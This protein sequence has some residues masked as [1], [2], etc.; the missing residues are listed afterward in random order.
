MR[1]S[2]RAVYRSVMGTG[3]LDSDDDIAALAT[4]QGT[5][6]LAVTR[7]AGPGCVERLARVFSRPDV[8]RS[9]AGYA[10][11]YGK[12]LDAALVP[13]D[14]VVAVVFRSPRSYTGQDGVDIMGHGG[15]ASPAR[16]MDA[17]MA[18][19]F[20]LALPGEFTFRAFASGRI[21][22]ARAEAVDELVRARTAEAQ[23]DALE[24]LGGGLSRQ[25]DELIG[26]LVRLAAACELRLD[27]GEDEHPE[28]FAEAL[29]ALGAV[30]ERC[31]E[32]AD[33]YA[34]GR[35]RDRG[36]RVALAGKTNAG[37]SSLF[38]R[39]LKEERALVSAHP[40]T[41]RDYLEAELD[42]GGVPVV[43]VD[44]AGLRVT[45]DPV[46]EE[47]VRR[48]RLMA[49]GADLVVYVADGRH[50]LDEDDHAVLAAHPGAVLVWNKIDDPE[51]LS[52]PADWLPVS[53]RDGTGE[54]QLGAA[55]ARAL[56]ASAGE[57]RLRVASK[58]QHDALARARDA[59]TDA[60]RAFLD[61]EPLDAVAV[62]LAVA[63]DALRGIG[64]KTGSDDV[65]EA[66][67]SNFCVGK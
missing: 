22:L 24:R 13:V 35:L 25:L 2:C 44:T 61:G 34:V 31:A 39:L 60:E 1:G 62:D 12:V 16:V 29:P 32:L 10:A 47:G 33:S 4:P 9:A 59:L 37:K 53:A 41:T 48:T 45:S 57:A 38:N 36:A 6:A 28:D 14:E 67:F 18:A 49:E 19:G 65:L 30:R 50:A 40:G 54:R 21:D 58:R 8:L 15:M 63:L 20:R 55:I 3:Y 46:E 43:L 5:G 51:A 42:L 7:V 27:Y 56:G 52:A 66:L 64:G 23:A 17:L 11:V 26:E